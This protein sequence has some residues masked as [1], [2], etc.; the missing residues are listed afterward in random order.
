MKSGPPV[1]KALPPG[2]PP[3][4]K[5]ASFASRVALARGSRPE[6][7]PERTITVPAFQQLVSGSGSLA[8][9]G[10][11]MIVYAAPKGFRPTS[12]A[13]GDAAIVQMTPDYTPTDVVFTPTSPA[14][15]PETSPDYGGSSPDAAS[16]NEPSPQ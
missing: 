9:S 2:P 6:P 5:G 7:P 15:R 10:P 4:P 14:P 12:T 13:G 8:K 16:P 11:P 1:L 3:V